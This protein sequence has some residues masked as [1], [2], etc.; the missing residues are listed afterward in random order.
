MLKRLASWLG[1]L[2]RRD[3]FEDDLDE[4][5][6]FHIQTRSADFVRQGMAPDEAMRRARLAF[7]SIEKQKDLARESFGLRLI[8]EVR[9]DVRLALRRL[10]SRPGH[11]LL[12]VATIAVGIG[13]A[14][15]VFSVVDQTVLRP[16]P[17]LDAD[18]LVDVLDSRGSDLTPAKILGWQSQPAMFQRLEAYAPQQF[19]LRGEGNPERIL[20]W[21]V[22]PGLFDM[23]GVAPHLGRSFVDGD[24]RPGGEP[25]AIISD[26]LWRRRFGG[27]PDVLGRRI[28]LNDREYTVIGVMPRRF[29]LHSEDDDVWVPFDL[30]AHVADPAADEFYAI[31]RLPGGVRMSRAQALADQLADR[32]E[33][34]MPLRGTWQLSV[35]PKRIVD[36]DATTRTAMFVLLG[37]VVFVLL[38][39]CANVI[40]ILLTDVPGRLRE[41][42]VRSALGGSRARL[43]RSMLVETTALAGA[44]GVLGVALAEWAVKAIVAALPKGTLWMT[45]TTIEV[46]ARVLWVA[47]AMTAA[48]ALCVGIVPALRGS[49][50][51]PDSILKS[52]AGRTSTGRLP[53]ALVVAEVAFS[54]MLLAGAALMTRTLVDLESIDP[55]FDPNGLVAMNVGL[56]S[57]RYPSDAARAR[58]FDDIQERIA[59]VPGV[60]GTAVAQGVPPR[61]GGFSFG[62]V[63]DERGVSRTRTTVVWNRVTPAY[64]AVMRT[65]IVEGRSFRDNEPA[66]SVIV[67]QTL[68]RLL[69]QGRSAVGRRVKIGSNPWSTVVGVVKTVE[70]RIGSDRRVSLQMYRPWAR[71]PSPGPATPTRDAPRTYEYRQVIVRA[72]D[73]LAAVPA[74]E[75]QIWS[76]DSAQPIEHVAL[77]SDMYG[78]AF[79]RQRFVLMLMSAFSIV[80]LVLTAAG[81]FGLLAQM[82]AQRTRE[83]GI[84][85]AL[86]ARRAQ[87]LRMI[88]T[89]GMTLTL[90]G[91]AIGFAGALAL[92]PVLK[93]LLFEVTP[94]DP[95][96]YASVVALLAIVALAACWLPARAATRVDPAE[97]LRVE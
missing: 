32:L 67:S 75:R 18:R 19:D 41:M 93:S 6:R 90:A 86:G 59:H 50:A 68:A 56:P 80:A 9:A 64:F 10:A 66:D 79:G 73:P 47:W 85:M 22:S 42:A 4:E 54:L 97:A 29:R 91:A 37:A 3:A 21:Q 58:F 17:F 5:V 27:A 70:T 23:L 88:A 16:A 45:T 35:Q 76:V 43:M 63:Q 89:R 62:D 38:I 51:K 33:R 52:G 14:T 57:D 55:G 71:V 92:A 48:T 30:R 81:I 83:I 11:A 25:V 65:P 95:V 28:A 77:V 26:A 96:S 44:G 15:A 49:R 78:E 31:G 36:V 60:M 94:T 12:I 72:A 74:I 20:A 24:G 13:A 8:D 1:A 34:E 84:R 69:A 46:D 40:S 7:G 53:G 61:S 87:L 2:V 39:T 82:V